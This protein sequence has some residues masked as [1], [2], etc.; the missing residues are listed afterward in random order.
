MISK[1]PHCHRL[2]TQAVSLE[3]L[4]IR[5]AVKKASTYI[6]PGLQPQLVHIFLCLF[7]PLLIPFRILI[8]I[9]LS[10]ELL[11][12]HFH[13]TPEHL[14][15][16]FAFLPVDHFLLTFC[17][18]VTDSSKYVTRDTSCFQVPAME[19]TRCFSYSH[20]CILEYKESPLKF[21][22]FLYFRK[23]AVLFH[24]YSKTPKKGARSS[25]I[26]RKFYCLPLLN[27]SS[28]NQLLEDKTQALPTLVRK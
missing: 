18:T 22:N 4:Q 9:S 2:S 3:A 5:R 7:Q 10:A 16:V 23:V 8:L 19:F 25:I 20:G 12:S 26:E 27:C 15:N 13:P 1:V 24:L 14:C 11:F 17:L 28:I 6:S 21:L